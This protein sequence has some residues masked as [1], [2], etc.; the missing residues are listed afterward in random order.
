MNA[1]QLELTL[2]KLQLI[3][4]SVVPPHHKLRWLKWW[5]SSV[6]TR[7]AVRFPLKPVNDERLNFFIVRAAWWGG[8]SFSINIDLLCL[9]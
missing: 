4:T 8:V 2:D 1:S 6:H 5:N 3:A 7:G 9:H